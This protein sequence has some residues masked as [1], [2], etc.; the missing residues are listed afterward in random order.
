MIKLGLEVESRSLRLG[1]RASLEVDRETLAQK[2]SLD[3]TAKARK[4]TKELLKVIK[5]KVK[6]ERPR[7]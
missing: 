7:A 4:L 1:D 3:Q 6:N 2:M 5:A